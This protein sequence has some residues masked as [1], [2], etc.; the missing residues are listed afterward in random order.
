MMPKTEGAL[1]LGGGGEA[2]QT[3]QNLL[4]RY[5]NRHGLIAGATGTG[6]TVTLQVMAEE[7]SAAGVPVFAADVKGDLAGLSQAGSTSAK[8]HAAFT[9]RAAKIGY[10]LEYQS[11]PVSFWDVFGAEGLP[12]RCTI[13]E[14][15]PQLL[16]QILDLSPAQEGALF[17]AFRLADEEGLALLDLKDLRA[18]LQFMAGEEK[19]ISARYGLISGESLAAL[20]RGLLLLEEAGAAALFGEPALDFADFLRLDSSGR[21]QINILAAS[22]LLRAPRLYAI[23]LLWLLTELFE[24]LPEVGDTD[25]PKLVF[26]FDEAHLLFRLAPKALLEEIEQLVRL[27][28]SKGVG[29]FF[30][31]QNPADVPGII[32]GQLGNRVQHGLRAFTGDEQRELRRASETYRANP[33]FDIAEALPAL[34]VGE[35]VTSFLEDKGV[36]GMA[37]RTLIRPPRT[38]L[39]AITPNE[40]AAQIA[41]DPLAARYAQTLDRES[42]FELLSARLA[43]AE[44]PAEAAETHSQGR[45]ISGQAAAPPAQRPAARRSD[46]LSTAFAKSF[47]RQIGTRAGGALVRGLLGTLFRG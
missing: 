4:L 24:R 36:P 16:A 33:R 22:R 47:V 40:R 5:A 27:V 30:V 10:T 1:S 15:G 41:A 34:A 44:A 38:R 17:I 35:A 31:T 14:M 3:P 6:K 29:V 13:S 45:R 32:L 23:F 28:R 7:F 39:G 11:F 19:A 46:S 43:A 37:E 26:F 8:P 25:K 21:G 20:Q 12:L 2:Y 9:E 18:V 42:A